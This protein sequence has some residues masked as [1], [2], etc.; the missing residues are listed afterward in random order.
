MGSVS[1]TS[2]HTCTMSDII[3]TLTNNQIDSPIY[4]PPID[5]AKLIATVKE[6]C[7]IKA[8]NIKFRQEIALRDRVA[9]QLKREKKE[10]HQAALKRERKERII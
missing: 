9:A 2:S 1:F 5:T 3:Q 7:H 4:D 6:K 10:K 8:A